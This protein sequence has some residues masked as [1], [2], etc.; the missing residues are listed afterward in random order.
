MNSIRCVITSNWNDIYNLWIALKFKI[1]CITNTISNSNPSLCIVIQ[2]VSWFDCS[3]EASKIFSSDIWES[4]KT[5]ILD[6]HTQY[7]FTLLHK[8]HRYNEKRVVYNAHT[9]DSRTWE[10]ERASLRLIKQLCIW[11]F[12][13]LAFLSTLDYIRM[14]TIG[15][16]QLTKYI[17]W[18]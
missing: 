2:R 13:S 12:V 18:V 16:I 8:P 6:R 17:G 9:T 3:I 7:P 1:E 11:T 15:I 4:F 10:Q 5:Q 14:Y